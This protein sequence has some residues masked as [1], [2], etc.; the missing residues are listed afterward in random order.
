MGKISHSLLL[1]IMAAPVRFVGICG[2]GTG[3]GGQGL[4]ID[5]NS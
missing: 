2:R 3:P 4:S 1:A 5:G